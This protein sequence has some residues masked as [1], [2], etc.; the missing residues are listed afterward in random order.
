MAIEHND[1]EPKRTDLLK[2]LEAKGYRR[3]HSYQAGRLLRAPLAA[4]CRCVFLALGLEDVA[5]F[6]VP[7][8]ELVADD[9]P[10]HR[11][12]AVDQLAV[13]DGVGAEVVGQIGRCDAHTSSGDV[14]LPRPRG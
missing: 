1:E 3:V 10:I 5:V 13:D 4:W 14:V 2:F 7:E 8:V 6:A 12:G 9:R 11:V